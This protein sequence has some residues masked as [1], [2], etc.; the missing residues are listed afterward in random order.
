M[1]FQ[2]LKIP[3]VAENLNSYDVYHAYSEGNQL[4]LLA[5]NKGRHSLD[6]FSLEEGRFVKA[7]SLEHQGPNGI[8]QVGSLFH[9]NKDSIFMFERGAL[10]IANSEGVV[11]DSFKLFELFDIAQDGEPVVNFYFKLNYDPN[12][13]NVLFYL[14]SPQSSS[15]S[16][17]AK[18]GSLNIDSRTVERLPIYHTDYHKSINGRVGFVTYLG[19][20]D[21][22]KG[23]LLYN[24]Q[25]ES[26]LFLYDLNS[27]ETEFV[28]GNGASK[29]KFIP[30]V[31]ASDAFEVFNQHALDNIHYLT[32]IPDK[33]RGL[34]YRINWGG[35]GD[36]EEA[37]FTEKKQS[38]SVFD[39]ELNFL[40]EFSL[41]DHTYQIN[42][43]FV[44]EKGLH[45][46]KAHPKYENMDEE[47]LI[48][49][50][51]NFK[52]SS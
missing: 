1:T 20:Y 10:R 33:W 49:D 18:I 46:N 34:V 29:P 26:S 9:H 16:G 38:I 21:Y 41:P 47:H 31:P 22:F 35:P 27:G 50:I 45:L 12:T 43:W 19:F 36:Y 52:Q 3:I 32:V 5:Y 25:Y 13:K 51:I 24:F 7:L 17:S 23:K 39:E 44:N 15:V 30:A 6:Y 4:M 11:V 8:G 28:S 14:N 48:F 42:N 2:E 37:G 40:Q